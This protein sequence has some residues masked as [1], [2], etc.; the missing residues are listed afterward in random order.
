MADR[1]I[2]GALR[3]LSADLEWPT[4]VDFASTAST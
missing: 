2:E 4:P 1:T 3:D